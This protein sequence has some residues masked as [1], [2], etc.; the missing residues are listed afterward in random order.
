MKEIMQWPLHI[1]MRLM[2]ALIDYNIIEPS[3]TKRDLV[4]YFGENELLIDSECTGF[5]ESA[6]KT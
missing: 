4:A 2:A 1:V 3:D 5:A 6:A